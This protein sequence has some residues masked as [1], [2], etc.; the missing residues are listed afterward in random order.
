[1]HILVVPSWYKSPQTPVYGSFFEE[2]ARALQLLGHE[3]RVLY[4]VLLPFKFTKKTNSVTQINDDGL[5]TFNIYWSPYQPRIRKLSYYLFSKFVAEWFEGYIKQ[6][7]KPDVIHAHC[8][9]YAGIAAQY[10]A[11][12]Y[13]I[14]LVVSEHNTDFITEKNGNAIVHKTELRTAKKVL[15]NAQ[16]S[17]VVSSRFAADL[18]QKLKLEPHV[19]GVMPNMV[20]DDFLNIPILDLPPKTESFTFLSISFI[21]WRKNI[22]LLIDAFSQIHSQIPSAK[23]VIG[24]EGEDLAS[25]KDYVAQ[26]GLSHKIAFLG[27]L[28]RAQVVVQMQ[29]CQVYAFTS[30]YESFGVVLIEALAAGKPLISTNSAGPQDIVTPQNGILVPDFEVETF[31]NAMLEM[32]QNYDKYDPV[33]LRNDAKN[34]FSANTIMLKTLDIYTEI[35]KNNTK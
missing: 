32:Y 18:T 19:L 22:Q 31:A 10:L 8:V 1:M 33:A 23:L 28:D 35:V 27:Y 14:P 21:Y 30:F 26:L 29:Q 6:F 2:Q 4:P 34:R 9:F 25:L 13:N 7:G 20:K 11:Q 15:E 3:V 16:K 5:L 17:L 24:G 12:K